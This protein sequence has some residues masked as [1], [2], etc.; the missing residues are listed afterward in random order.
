M[1]NFLKKLGPGLITGAADDDP[2]G[3]ATYSLAGSKFGY[4]LLWTALFSFPLMVAVQETCGRIGLVT[5]KGLAEI[6]KEHYPRPV[7]IFVSVVL[8][9]ANTFNIG[10]NLS[11]MAAAIKLLVPLPDLIISLILAVAMVY[12]IIKLE[13]VKIVKV[14]KWLT[15]A[16]IAYVVTFFLTQQNYGEIILST[17]LPSFAFSKDYLLMLVAIF[18]TSISP[19]LFFWQTSEEA[20]T[21]K[22]EGKVVSRYSL[23]VEKNDTIAGMFF[24]TAGDVFYHRN[25]GECFICGGNSQH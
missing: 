18:G 2:S 21:E 14:F 4:G 1:K 25:N 17:M 3:I 16:L 12:L 5:K 6:T 15:L 13:Y 8:F 24:F 7:V 10:A 11:G 20:E 9:V 19:Y 23:R 22:L